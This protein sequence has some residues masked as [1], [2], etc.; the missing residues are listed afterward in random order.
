MTYPLTM[1]LGNAYMAPSMGWQDMP[2]ILLSLS[3]TIFAF[4]F[5]AAL[6]AL[7][8]ESNFAFDGPPWGKGATTLAVSACP[9][10][11]LQRVTDASLYSCAM[12]SGCTPW[13]CRKPPRMP[14]SPVTPF[15]AEWKEKTGTVA[16]RSI[17]TLRM[18]TNSLPSAWMLS[19]YTSSA[20][21]IN[22]SRSANL[23]M[24]SK[25]SRERTCPVGLPGL[26]TQMARGVPPLFRKSFAARSSS[27][28]LTP[29]PASSSR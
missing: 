26:I 22:L 8:S 17:A 24:L 21:T 23:R 19:W 7:R 10:T 14:H 15:E 28:T 5:S 6:M 4:R 1:I 9:S 29:Q 13:Q 2:S 20:S 16:P 3:V 11:L 25:T 12:T 18:D 27:S